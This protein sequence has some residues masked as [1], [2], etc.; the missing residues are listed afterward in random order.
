MNESQDQL[1]ALR[2]QREKRA[3]IVERAIGAGS[4]VAAVAILKRGLERL[5][6]DK[7]LDFLLGKALLYCADPSCAERL[8]EHLKFMAQAERGKRER[9]RN[10]WKQ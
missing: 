10:R 1:A 5:R 2:R 3:L 4:D 9:R 8:L 7:N 6:L